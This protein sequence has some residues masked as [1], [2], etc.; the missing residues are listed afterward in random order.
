M[1]H[2]A[3]FRIYENYTPVKMCMCHIHN[4]ILPLKCR[5]GTNVCQKKPILR[6]A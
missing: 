4:L 2:F 3:P 5:Q 6:D 1:F